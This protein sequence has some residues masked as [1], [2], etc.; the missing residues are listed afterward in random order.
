ME[1]GVPVTFGMAGPI[2]LAKLT[3]LPEL[4]NH[5]FKVSSEELR[6]P[7]CSTDVRIS[8]LSRKLIDDKRL[9]AVLLLSRMYWN[10][11]C[12]SLQ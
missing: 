12:L 8:R 4:E 1:S 9:V 10:D 2:L 3:G 5:S 11:I 6:Q 7:R